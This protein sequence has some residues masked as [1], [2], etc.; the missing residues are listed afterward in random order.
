MV[1][2]AETARVEFLDFIKRI[3][4]SLSSLSWIFNFY[5]TSSPYLTFCLLLRLPYQKI[6]IVWRCNKLKCLF[7]Q[8]LH[9]RFIKIRPKVSPNVP[10]VNRIFQKLIVTTSKPSIF[11]RIIRFIFPYFKIAVDLLNNMGLCLTIASELYLT[12]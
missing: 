4:G 12:L 2:K 11:V 8:L 9:K 6:I 7:Q 5:S 3:K 10:N 1:F